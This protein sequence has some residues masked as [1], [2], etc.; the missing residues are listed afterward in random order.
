MLTPDRNLAP[1]VIA[2]TD[3]ATIHGARILGDWLISVDETTSARPTVALARRTL[4]L[5]G[6]G[7][8]DPNVW[9]VTDA[10]AEDVI[11]AL[12]DR[13]DSKLAALTLAALTT[14]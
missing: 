9:R 10:A 8:E 13:D 5:G 3:D 14:K 7:V 1:G 11:K 12:A 6:A 4:D 2:H